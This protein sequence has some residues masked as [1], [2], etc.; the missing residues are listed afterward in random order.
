[1][2]ITDFQD[3]PLLAQL[4]MSAGNHLQRDT[5]IAI[6]PATKYRSLVVNRKDF[7][8]AVFL[9]QYQRNIHFASFQA[10]IVFSKTLTNPI[11]SYKQ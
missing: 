2:Q 5:E 10:A 7:F 4:A 8:T 1:M 11:V 3:L 6:R 9:Q